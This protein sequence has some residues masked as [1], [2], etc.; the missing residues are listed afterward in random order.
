MTKNLSTNTSDT[1]TPDT[2]VATDSFSDLVALMARL[3]QDCPWDKKQTNHSLIGYAIEEIYEL[4]GAILTGDTD[5]IKS[6]LGDVLLQVVFHACLYHE[7]GKFDINDVIFTLQ[8]KLI[9][10]HPH[11]FGAENLSTD[12]DV[13]RRWDEIK[14]AE[15]T[16][17]DKPR[18]TLIAKSSTAL[19]QADDIQKQ[20]SKVGFDWQ[21]LDGAWAKC[22]EEI[23][24]LQALLPTKD[25]P[26]SNIDKTKIT[27]ELGDCLFAL[28]NIARKLDINSEVALLMSVAKFKERFDFIEDALAKTGKTIHDSTLDE[29]DRLWDMA[30][31]LQKSP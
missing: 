6:E 17:K 21:T 20:A 19:L 1:N 29:M 4:I 24:E 30:K 22:H 15:N 12:T 13:K 5:D 3:R 27:E 11:V 23:A 9:R 31:T 8:D 7:Q 25:N 26:I 2:I 28:V 18:R 16:Q 10:R 14:H